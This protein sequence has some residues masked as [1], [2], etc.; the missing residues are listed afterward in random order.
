MCIFK[1][2]EAI[3][4]SGDNMAFRRPISV[5]CVSEMYSMCPF[6][7]FGGTPGR[8]LPFQS[9]LSPSTP[10]SFYHAPLPVTPLSG[11]IPSFSSI[12]LL[13]S[14][15]ALFNKTGNLIPLPFHYHQ[16]NRQ[17]TVFLLTFTHLNTQSWGFWVSVHMKRDLLNF[18][19]FS[20]LSDFNELKRLKKTPYKYYIVIQIPLMALWD[21]S[22]WRVRYK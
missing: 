22:E 2:S 19:S 4:S 15:P 11:S 14:S 8:P 17:Q 7:P 13:F 9:L 5:H 18:V 3:F 16:D 1:V 6:N 21:S 10:L 12:I 20:P